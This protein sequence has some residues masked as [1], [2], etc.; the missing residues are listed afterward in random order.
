MK[1][2]NTT[3]IGVLLILGTFTIVG[4][5]LLQDGKIGDKSWQMVVLLVVPLTGVGFVM[6]RDNGKTSEQVRAGRPRTDF[7]RPKLAL[8]CLIPLLMLGCGKQLTHF[9][10]DAQQVTADNT[11]AS[12]MRMDADGNLTGLYEGA[13]PSGSMQDETGTWTIQPGAIGILTVDPSSGRLYIASPKDVVMTDVEIT[14]RPADGQPFFR[15]A[16]VTANLSAVAAVYQQQYVSAVQGLTGMT[17]EAAKIQIKAWETT[18][19]IVPDVAKMLLDSFVPT[20][21]P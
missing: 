2:W 9:D 12:G 3:I 10:L 5:D 4:L 20:L 7:I 21:S 11:A 16:S 14:P 17:Q 19:Q 6:S 18:G 1:S 8:L 13:P 15:A